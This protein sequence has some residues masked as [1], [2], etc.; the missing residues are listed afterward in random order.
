VSV[1]QPDLLLNDRY[2]LD[3]RVASGGMAGERADPRRWRST[4]PRC[5]VSDA[6]G[7]VRQAMTAS[8]VFFRALG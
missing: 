4:R 6:L 7:G 1:P 3:E 2:R 8:M 5:W